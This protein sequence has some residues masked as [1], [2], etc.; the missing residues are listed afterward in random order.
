[1]DIFGIHAAN[2]MKMIEKVEKKRRSLDKNHDKRE[3]ET[4][5]VERNALFINFSCH[6]EVA[7]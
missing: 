4:L 2:A 3:K 7:G 5:P 1:M 6:F